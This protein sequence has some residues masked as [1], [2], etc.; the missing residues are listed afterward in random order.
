LRGTL[1]PTHHKIPL[2]RDTSTM[3]DPDA[4]LR[5]R[6]DFGASPSWTSFSATS[7][8]QKDST[9]SANSFQ[10][11]PAR[12][13]PGAY[14]PTPPDDHVP[15]EPL[16]YNATAPEPVPLNARYATTV[17]DVPDLEEENVL[18]VE[19]QVVHRGNQNTERTCRICLSGAEDG[20]VSLHLCICLHPIVCL[21]ASCALTAYFPFH[22]PCSR[23]GR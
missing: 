3:T 16:Q 8:S 20:T 6:F 13:L 15:Q 22:L 11:S 9:T 2:L 7:S 19:E 18:R 21:C 1:H 4:N 10:S 17:E 23:N 5:H 14:I 12:S